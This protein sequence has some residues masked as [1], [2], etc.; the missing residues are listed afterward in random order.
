MT[1]RRIYIAIGARIRQMRLRAGMSQGQ[2]AKAVEWHRPSVTNCEMGK[3]R[4]PIHQLFRIARAL[5]MEAIHLLPLD[6]DA[7]PKRPKRRQ[8]A[9]L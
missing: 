5:G 1:D 9:R 8:G 6:V 7:P 4:L 3:Q 2:L